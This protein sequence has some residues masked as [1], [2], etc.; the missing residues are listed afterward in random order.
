MSG[1]AKKTTSR[2]KSCGRSTRSQKPTASWIKKIN[3][4]YEKAAE[5][6]GRPP[7]VQN[8]TK[9]NHLLF[10][11][12]RGF[13]EEYVVVS[14]KGVEKSSRR[15]RTAAT[16]TRS[17]TNA[18]AKVKPKAKAKTKTKAGTQAKRRSSAKTGARAKA[19]S[20]GTKNKRRSK[21]TATR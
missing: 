5:K 13:A 11:G 2:C 17:K 19:K 20:A 12:E 18:R 6:L 7:A 21:V 8:C 1:A 9:C 4:R 14:P 16:K 10:E 3:A 15:K